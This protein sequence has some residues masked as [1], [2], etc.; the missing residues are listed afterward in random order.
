MVTEGTYRNLIASYR[1]NQIVADISRSLVPLWCDDYFSGNRGA[2]LVSVDLDNSGTVLTYIF[3]ITLQRTIVA[4][5][6]PI[7]AKHARDSGRM[8]GHP[9]SAG[10]DFHR[11][12]LIA[13]S[14]GGG[15]DINL[16][17]QLGKLNI[18][19]FR[20]IERRVRDMAK[21]N[22]SCLY[23]ARPIFSNTSQTPAMFEQGAILSG[24]SLIY[25]LHK[26][27]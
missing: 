25:S 23:F 5:G 10:P 15:T 4:Y 16:V 22:L 24:R 26:N 12:H 13:H 20:I 6:V 19:E 8:A 1:G 2:E 14:I 21:Q 27:S 18:R 3:D 11:G 17:P 7:F 9:N